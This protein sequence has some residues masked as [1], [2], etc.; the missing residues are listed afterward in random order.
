MRLLSRNATQLRNWSV[1]ALLLVQ[2]PIT[3]PSK[4]DRMP[5]WRSKNASLCYLKLGVEFFKSRLKLLKRL[6]S[7]VPVIRSQFI[8]ALPRSRRIQTTTRAPRMYSS[9]FCP[10]M[11]LLT[12]LSLKNQGKLLWGKHGIVR[13]SAMACGMGAQREHFPPRNCWLSAF[14]QKN[15]TSSSPDS[16]SSPACDGRTSMT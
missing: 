10:G 1:D 11:R 8:G 9:T 3:G 13:L 14:P 15:F 6:E 4:V 12:C 5:Y 7:C 2:Q 16:R